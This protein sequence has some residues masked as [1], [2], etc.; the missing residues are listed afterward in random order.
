MHEL[1]IADAIAETVIEQA[2]NHHASHV[3]HVSVRIGEANAIVSEALIFCFEVIA[4]SN[5][6]LTGAQLKVDII[7]HQARCRWCDCEFH[8]VQY[9]TQCPRCGH[10]EA[11]MLSGTEFLIQDMEID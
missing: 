8:V 9:I 1:S 5:P 6:L 3:K 4:S 10:W 2:N 11:E 7:P